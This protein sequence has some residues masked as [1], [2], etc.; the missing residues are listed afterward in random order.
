MK[1][2]FPTRPL[3][4][5]DGEQYKND[6]IELLFALSCATI[7][8]FFVVGLWFVTVHADFIDHVFKSW[9]IQFTVFLCVVGSVGYWALWGRK[10]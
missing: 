9:K 3:S 8:W 4:R 10:S 5:I 1:R 2:R 6:T 7:G